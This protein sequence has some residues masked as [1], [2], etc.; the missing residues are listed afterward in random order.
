MTS[1]GYVYIEYYDD[2]GMHVKQYGIV[3][4]V[5]DLITQVWITG[6]VVSAEIIS[7]SRNM[8]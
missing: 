7:N 1:K 4:S 8:L 3:H 2:A 5:C 6:K